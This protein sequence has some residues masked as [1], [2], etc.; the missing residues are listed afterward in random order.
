[1]KRK[2]G[3]IGRVTIA[4]PL[5]FLAVVRLPMLG[6]AL[7]STWLLRR[8][9]ISN[10]YIATIA[11]IAVVIILGW[12][13]GVAAEVVLVFTTLGIFEALGTWSDAIKRRRV[14]R[15]ILRMMSAQSSLVRGTA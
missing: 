8:L 12:W 1:M 5:A 13:L 7:G 4:L 6:V 15:R 11:G 14:E 10:A 3:K 2:L 9:K